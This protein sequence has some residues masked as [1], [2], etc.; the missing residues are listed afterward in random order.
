MSYHTVRVT[1]WVTPDTYNKMNEEFIT[2]GTPFRITPTTQEDI[3]A[4]IERDK[5]CFPKVIHKRMM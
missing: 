2:D 4:R 3:D 1:E 5:R